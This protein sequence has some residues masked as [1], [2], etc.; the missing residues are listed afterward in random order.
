[1][2]GLGLIIIRASGGNFLFFMPI[3]NKYVLEL[4]QEKAP[5]LGSALQG[6][7]NL[8]KKGLFKVSLRGRFEDRY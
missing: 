4:S 7:Y 6:S 5:E 1:M 2:S 3:H 8:L